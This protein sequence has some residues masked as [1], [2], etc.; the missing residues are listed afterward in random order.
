M[1]LTLVPVKAYRRG[2]IS[3]AP[4]RPVFSATL[5]KA[6]L[7]LS[8]DQEPVNVEAAA[9]VSP[10]TVPASKCQEALHRLRYP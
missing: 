5:C 8:I 6:A 7:R 10:S 9:I 4:L 3:F 2:V 1:Y